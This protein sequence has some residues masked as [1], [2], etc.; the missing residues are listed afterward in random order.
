MCGDQAS[1]R[2]EKYNRFRTYAESH[3]VAM[4]NAYPRV[5]FAFI[6]ATWSASHR[7]QVKATTFQVQA[8]VAALIAAS[9][10]G[11]AGDVR[12]MLSQVPIDTQDT[13]RHFNNGKYEQQKLHLRRPY[14]LLCRVFVQDGN[15][16][17][18]AAS[19]NNR[20]NVVQFLL[21]KGANTNMQRRVSKEPS[22]LCTLF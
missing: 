21:E 2:A 22:L 11:N 3:W 1:K 19:A 4:M 5:L 8:D 16:A 10:E 13:V 17:L 9:T 7:S 15:T 20:T 12:S 6:L 18:M 14:L